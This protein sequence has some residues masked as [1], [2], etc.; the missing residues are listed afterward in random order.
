MFIEFKDILIN[1]RFIK[2]IGLIENK[3][4]DSDIIGYSIFMEGEDTIYKKNFDKNK[5]KE[6]LQE[7]DNIK[8]TILGKCY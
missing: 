3:N 6:A 5:L 1:T 2:R 8:K 4:A 7:A